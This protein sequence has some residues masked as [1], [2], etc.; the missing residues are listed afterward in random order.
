MT[1]YLSSHHI[2]FPSKSMDTRIEEYHKMLYASCCPNAPTN[3][4][5]ITLSHPKSHQM[6][7]VHHYVFR[8]YVSV[9]YSICVKLFNRRANLLH[10]IC[11][12]HLRHGLTSLQLLVKLTTQGHLQNNIDVI[13]V[14]KTTIHLDDVWMTQ[15]HLDLDLSDKLIH[16]VLLL[17]Y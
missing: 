14:V 12:F 10:Q 13:F 15:V 5:H 3:Q 8:F 6:Y 7:L 9:N 17:Q 16:D 11:S 1:K 2:R 4:N